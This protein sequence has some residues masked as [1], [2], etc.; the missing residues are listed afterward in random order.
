[1]HAAAAGDLTGSVASG[2]GDVNGDGVD[3]MIVSASNQLD[4]HV[5]GHAYLVFGKTTGF[6]SDL[7]L[8]D[9]DGTDG[10]VFKVHQATSLG[11][12]SAASAT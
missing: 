1:M 8:G 12:P 9:L 6:D 2:A 7:N 11:C 3:D 10:Y 5:H 4:T